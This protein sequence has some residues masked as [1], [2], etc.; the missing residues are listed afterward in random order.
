MYTVNYPASTDGLAPWQSRMSTPAKKIE[1]CQTPFSVPSDGISFSI[2]DKD[3]SATV[4]SGNVPAIGFYEPSPGA[5]LGMSA[6]N[7]NDY[8]ITYSGYFI[9]PE[10]GNYTFYFAAIGKVRMKL[11]GSYLRIANA[12]EAGGWYD[13]T[14]MPELAYTT[15]SSLSGNNTG[16]NISSAVQ[17]VI[18]YWKTGFDAAFVA[19]FKNDKN[20]QVPIPISAGVANDSSALKSYSELP[21]ISDIS[22]DVAERKASEM[23]FTV[24][25]ISKSSGERGYYYDEALDA[26]VYSGDSSIFIKAKR[27][28]RGYVGYGSTLTKQFVGRVIDFKISRSKNSAD[29][30]VVTCHDFMEMLKESL[31]LS[32]PDWLDY[33]MCGY[34]SDDSMKNAGVIVSGTTKPPAWDYFPLHK[35]VTCML[36]RGGIDATLMQGRYWKQFSG[37]GVADTTAL[38]P[39]YG[40]ILDGN[41]YYSGTVIINEED[42]K[43]D[44]NWPGDTGESVLDSLLKILDNFGLSLG[45]L[46]YYDGAPT[47]IAPNSPSSVTSGRSLANSVSPSLATFGAYSSGWAVPSQ[48]YESSAIVSSQ[49]GDVGQ[50][51]VSGAGPEGANAINITSPTD[52]LLL[53]STSGGL[54]SWMTVYKGNKYTFGIYAK[55]LD[56]KPMSARLRV[57]TEA[58]PDKESGDWLHPWNNIEIGEIVGD[59]KQYSVTLTAANTERMLPFVKFDSS[60]DVLVSQAAISPGAT[61]QTYLASESS[62]GWIVKAASNA[63]G[64]EFQ[65]TSKSGAFLEAVVSGSRIEIIVAKGPDGGPQDGGPTCSY[66]VKRESDGSVVIPETDLNLFY[67]PYFSDDYPFGANYVN[68]GSFE[69]GLDGWTKK[70]L[71]G[72]ISLSA[73]DAKPYDSGSS[74]WYDSKAGASGEI[75]QDIQTVEGNAYLFSAMSFRTLFTAGSLVKARISYGASIIK[76][77]NLPLDEEEWLTSSLSFT[78]KGATT[79]ISF[80]FS[81]AVQGYV[82]KVKVECTSTPAS[83]NS[84]IRCYYDGV[85]QSGSNPCVIT[86]KSLPS[87]SALQSDTYRVRITSKTNYYKTRIDAIRAYAINYDAPEDEFVSG[88]HSGARGSLNSYEVVSTSS[89][90]RNDCIVVG[91]RYTTS[92]ADESRGEVPTDMA[93]A[94]YFA[95]AVDPESLYKKSA[96]NYLGFPSQTIVVEPELKSTRRAEHISKMVVGRYGMLS[97]KVDIVTTGYPNMSVFSCIALVDTTKGTIP[98]NLYWVTGYRHTLRD[99]YF[100]TSVN[101]TSSP[102]WTPYIPKYKPVGDDVDSMIRDVSIVNEANPRIPM[103]PDNPYDPYLSE[104]RKYIR[105]QFDLLIDCHLRVEVIDKFSN[106]TVAVLTDPTASKENDGYAKY[107]AG[108]IE[109]RWDGVN[110]FKLAG[111][112]SYNENEGE[113][114]NK[115]KIGSG[116]YV[117]EHCKDGDWFKND[118]G[119]S[120]GRFYVVIS[121]KDMATLFPYKYSTDVS[122]QQ[123]YIYTKRGPTTEYNVSY[124]S[125]IDSN[126]QYA[127]SP[128][129]FVPSAGMEVSLSCLTKDRKLYQAGIEANLMV[130][131]AVVTKTTGSFSWWVGSSYQQKKV[132]VGVTML[133]GNNFSEGQNNA[134]SRSFLESITLIDGKSLKQYSGILRIENI[135]SFDSINWGFYIDKIV[136]KAGST[137]L[138]KQYKN[139]WTRSSRISDSGSETKQ[140]YVCPAVRFVTVCTDKS[141]RI[142]KFC[143]Y[144]FWRPA[145]SAGEPLDRIRIS[146]SSVGWYNKPE[147]NIQYTTDVYQSDAE[148]GNCKEFVAFEFF[149]KSGTR[150]DETPEK[151][152]PNIK[153]LSGRHYMWFYKCGEVKW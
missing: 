89:D 8:V 151:G 58:H 90:M 97:N 96:R 110:S 41:I 83:S 120:F 37:S 139:A 54:G 70:G 52:T 117:V 112:R 84:S 127:S 138:A 124:G 125:K 43:N 49:E 93:D 48:S 98:N 32:Y 10:P 62:G 82:D 31:T 65:E 145:H 104:S 33:A 45:F 100:I 107:E 133:N 79:R 95:R 94:Y 119:K 20:Y 18:E 64:G 101:V 66:Q 91:G 46:G 1:I 146:G 136:E 71:S 50:R 36:F 7:S 132:A 39:D 72:D 80:I 121:V 61:P 111:G 21:L 113:N 149:Q 86:I 47:I 105:V 123:S 69:S 88:P 6:E 116:Y 9:P 92:V 16:Q 144:A 23:V 141:G 134:E 81:G 57:A 2:V 153:G 74:L 78:A 27:L 44:F 13:L 130:S 14:D 108:R 131:F 30:L 85:D 17:F 28:I 5:F 87:G 122:G 148:W 73:T 109:L 128:P 19:M 137:E 63:I 40:I 99:G 55:N 51:V 67:A 11:G 22:I 15:T 59:W 106:V 150:F 143:H 135:F 152:Y 38:I 24:P 56:S 68:N 60:G 75:Y 102:P 114:H 103:D 140:Y 42:K 76:E 53:G 29:M 142:R 118:D 115:E 129:E 147:M 4:L 35:V 126:N 12:K 26:F 25:L 77:S 3:K 34:L